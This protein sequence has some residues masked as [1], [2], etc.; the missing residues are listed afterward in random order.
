MSKDD[1]GVNFDIWYSLF[2]MVI[3]E[4]DL[5]MRG[6]EERFAKCSAFFFNNEITL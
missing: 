1:G 2:P 6:V 4:F 5:G 3:W